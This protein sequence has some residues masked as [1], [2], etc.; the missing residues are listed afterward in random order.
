MTREREDARLAAH[1]TGVENEAFTSR[2]TTMIAPRS[3]EHRHGH[4]ARNAN[5]VDESLGENRVV[6]PETRWSAPR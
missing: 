1:E 3:V 6:V 2:T 5:D 4:R